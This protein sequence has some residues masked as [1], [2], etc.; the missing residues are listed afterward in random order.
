[1]GHSNSVPRF[2]ITWGTGPGIVAP[3]AARAHQAAE[4]G[5]LR[6]AFRHRVDEL[7]RAAGSVD[8]VR[9][10]VLEPS[11]VRRSA[12]SSRVTIGDFELHAPAVIVTSGG[13]GG[14]WT[15]HNRARVAQPAG[16]TGPTLS[17][18]ARSR[19]ARST[20]RLVLGGVIRSVSETGAWHVV[21]AVS[22]A[23][24]LPPGRRLIGLSDPGSCVAGAPRGAP[25]RRNRAAG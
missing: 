23:W 22:W 8:G 18:H 1:M 7:T 17:V 6:W 11:A 12:P 25:L 3:F 19:S 24:T 15:N 20:W 10:A 5:Q 9:G 16:S 13:I 4:R 21:I 14:N 2:H